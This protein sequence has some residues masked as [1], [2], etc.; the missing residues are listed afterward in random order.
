MV[1]TKIKIEKST[2]SDVFNRGTF[3]NLKNRANVRNTS[4]FVNISAL[5]VLFI[6]IDAG[7]NRNIINNS[8]KDGVIKTANVTIEN[9]VKKVNNLPQYI[10]FKGGVLITFKKLKAKTCGVYAMGA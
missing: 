9:H 6:L 7:K 1:I 10:I 8:L 4:A 5:R 3:L 2:N